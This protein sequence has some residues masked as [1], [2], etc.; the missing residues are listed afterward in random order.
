MALLQLSSG[1][2]CSSSSIPYP[3]IPGVQIRSVEAATARKGWQYITPGL[4]PNGPAISAT[5]VNF[6]NVSI[7]YTPLD[8]SRITTVQVWLPTEK[9]NERIQA[10][11]G[12]GW[13]AGLNDVSFGGMTAAVI[14]G[15]ATMTTNGGHATSNP[16]DWVFSS[17]GVVD[18]K[19]FQHFATTS[20]NDLALI[21][22]AVVGSFYGQA[23]KYSYWNGCSQGGRQGFTLAQNYPT[24]FNGIAA[25]APIVNWSQL[26]VAGFWSQRIMNEENHYP[27]SCELAALKTA[28]IKACDPMDGVVDGMISDPD[29][30]HF[31]PFTMVNTTISCGFAGPRNISSTAAKMAKMGWTGISKDSVHNY[32]HRIVNN[33]EASLVT[34]G[35]VPLISGILPY[36]NATLGLADVDCRPDGTCVG[37]PY[38][39][40]SDWIKLFVQKDPNFDTSKIK[41]KEFDRIF[42]A[43]VDEYA[44]IIG[45]DNP[46][47]SAFHRA[48]GKLLSFHGLV[49]ICAWILTHISRHTDI[50]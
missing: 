43:S 1:L 8:T 24:A 19:S 41:Q 13:A 32:M 48:G 33:H 7:T 17:P 40:V 34:E 18:K 30:C 14:Q 31:D 49:S 9:W 45:T 20:L 28:A 4:N 37:H 44:S 12:G 35:S 38:P 46:D 25:S 36:L 23:P 21:G 6:C 26:F 10:I 27:R 2:N 16:S 47:L 22:K 39:Q 29:S 42:Q 11:G 3:N 50:Y 5:S 15:Y